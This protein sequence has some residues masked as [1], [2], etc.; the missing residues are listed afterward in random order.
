MRPQRSRPHSRGRVARGIA[1]L[2]ATAAVSGCSALGITDQVDNGPPR[3]EPNPQ[4]DIAAAMVD[5]RSGPESRLNACE[6]L[7]LTTAEI[8]ALTGADMPDVEPTGSG[9]LRLL[10]TYGGPGSPERYEMQ[11]SGI[12][13]DD[14][15]GTEAEADE[16]TD[17][18]VDPEADTDSE[19]GTVFG[20]EVP[21][22]LATP[23]DTTAEA[24]PTPTATAVTTPEVDPDY[25]PDT[26]AAGV[27]KPFEGPQDALGN[28]AA[29]LGVRYACSDIRGQDALSVDAVAPGAPEAPQPV[30]PDLATAYI[31]CAAAP[32]G[33]GV[34]VHTILI[35]D[36]DLWH[37]TLVSS[38]T[39]SSPE[40][41]ALALQGLHRV[42]EY[43]LD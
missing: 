28:H 4:P 12:T 29:M 27:V 26:F 42:A 34:E 15:N 35:A 33:G 18:D 9:D 32:T 16:T 30:E 21:S 14:E 37:I 3:L 23:D 19:A 40:A 7:D 20:P 13:G 22:A 39:P 43:I 31:D 10:C 2:A 6:L 8:I 41:E 24:Q 25:L 17:A 1:A 11:L 36:N 38:E 5:G